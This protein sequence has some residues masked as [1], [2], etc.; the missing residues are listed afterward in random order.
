MHTGAIAQAYQ[1]R[2]GPGIDNPLSPDAW[3]ARLASLPLLSQ[4]GS[5]MHYGHSTDLLG[6]LIA[7]IEGA[8]LDRVLHRRIF[9]RLGM[10]DTSF[11]IHPGNAHRKAALY[12]HD[13]SGHLVP[14]LT[15]PGGST[16]IQRPDD[17]QFASG[18]Q[19]LWSTADDYLTFARLFV[20]EGSVDGVRILRPETVAMM[21]TNQLTAAQRASA[22]I[23]GMPLLGEGHGFG[24]GVAVVMDEK[25]A[26]STPCGGSVGSS[27][28]PGAFGGWW[29]ADPRR[30]TVL[31]FLCHNAMEREQFETGIGLGVYDVIHRF[32]QMASRVSTSSEFSPQV[33]A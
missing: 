4:P 14:R 26:S 27:G 9:D 6:F 7:R 18:G 30:N 28:W 24:L 21:T 25:K 29:R 19:G 2:V 20:Q 32:Q 17:M 1:E 16:M 11:S 15:A 13:S 12:G 23:F 10:K 33:S 3:I 5:Q 31:V 8:S 22:T